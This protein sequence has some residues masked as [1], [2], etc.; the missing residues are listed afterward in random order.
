MK[1]TFHLNCLEQGGAERVV[2]NLSDALVHKGHEVHIAT[3]WI[4]ENE[5]TPDSRVKRFVVGLKEDE[6]KKSRVGKFFRRI[7]SLKEYM[8]KEKPD[9]L[10]AFGQRANYRALMAEKG[11]DVPVVFCVRTNPVGNYDRFTDRIQNRLLF[12][13]AAGAVFQTS[14]QRDF[15]KPHC[16]ENATVILNPVAKKYVDVPAPAQRERSV[17][18]SARLVDFKN[19]PMLVRAFCRVHEKHPDY[20]LKIYGGDSFDGTREILEALIRERKA[21]DFVFLMGA[22]DALEKE[23]VKGSVFAFSSDWEGLPN[24]LIEAMALGLPVVATNCPCGGPAELITHEEN[25]LLVPIMDEEAMADG[26]CRLIEDPALA[27]RLGEA[28]RKITERT[29]EDV[30]VKQWETYLTEVVARYREKQK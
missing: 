5:F 8:Q 12:P 27:G 23:L 20:V 21:E 16:P 2:T 26:I 17:V 24:A 13:R 14:E 10:V 25:G 7:R 15:F 9:V 6:E 11:T 28:A 19:Q 3:E 29:G 30:I 22:S 4:G 18:Q 1:I